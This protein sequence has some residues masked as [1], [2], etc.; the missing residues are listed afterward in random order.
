MYKVCKLDKDIQHII[1]LILWFRFHIYINSSYVSFVSN[2]LSSSLVVRILLFKMNK[3]EY[4]NSKSNLYIKY[5][6]SI[7]WAILAVAGTFASISNY[8]YFTFNRS[9]FINFN[10]IWKQLNIYSYRVYISCIE[11]LVEKTKS[12][13][14]I[15]CL[16]KCYAS[17]MHH[18]AYS[19]KPQYFKLNKNLVCTN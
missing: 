14:E 1:Y 9:V 6:I 17:W 4:S 10:Q 5:V 13:I 8:I 15:C 12:W 7:N 11:I 16:S 18:N 3:W 19:P 2:F